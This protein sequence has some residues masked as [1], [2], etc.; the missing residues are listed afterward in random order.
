MMLSLTLTSRVSNK[1]SRLGE[2]GFENYL[3]SIGSKRSGLT[4]R[5]KPNIV[6]SDFTWL[7]FC[8]PHMAI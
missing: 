2:I 8:M 1:R 5:S 7:I 4:T 3:Y 6:A